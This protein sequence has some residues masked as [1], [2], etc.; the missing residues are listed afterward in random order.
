MGSQLLHFDDL[1]GRRQDQPAIH[2]GDEA[3]FLVEEA[4]FQSCAFGEEEAVAGLEML[5]VTG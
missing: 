5:I 4:P 2:C 3:E 1:V